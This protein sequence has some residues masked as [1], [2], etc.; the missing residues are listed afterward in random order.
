MSFECPH[1]TKAIEGIVPKSRFDEKSAALK[2]AD[3][4]I[5]RIP[6]LEQEVSAAS[7]LREELA[8]ARAGITDERA[9]RRLL[10]AYRSDVEG[11]DQPA[12]LADWLRGDGAD[13]VAR[14][15]VRAAPV[16]A[17]APAV[18]APAAP[19]PV[20]A[21]RSALPRDTGSPPPQPPG[22]GRL[23]EAQVAPRLAAL[24]SEYRTAPSD[25]RTAIRGEI[26]ALQ[27]QA[28]TG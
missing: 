7:R 2:A 22:T 19:A 21:P 16:V 5:A 18:A 17:D 14:Y 24:Q 10:S 15:T 28:L 8:L 13:D 6:A 12:P 11:T 4:K 25:R 1:C 27:A 26:S 20:V 3:E 23:T 9:A